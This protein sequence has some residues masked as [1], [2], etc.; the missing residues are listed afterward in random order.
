MFKLLLLK[1]TTAACGFGFTLFAVNSDD[2]KLYGS[3]INTDS[4]IG[5][6]I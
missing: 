3:G 6:Y 2:H 4:Q 5:K 1:V